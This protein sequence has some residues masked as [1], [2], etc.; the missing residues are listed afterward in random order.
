M[1][2]PRKSSDKKELSTRAK[3]SIIIDTTRPIKSPAKM[4]RHEGR[5]AAVV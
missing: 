1:P 4:P 2:A 3:A 5:L